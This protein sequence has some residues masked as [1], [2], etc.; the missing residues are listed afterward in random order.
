MPVSRDTLKALIQEYGGIPLSDEEL[1]LV[2]PEVE[3]YLGEV[4]Q[5]RDLDLS[6]VMSGRLMRAAEGEHSDG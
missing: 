1:D 5:L 2:T 4:A 3:S 6:S